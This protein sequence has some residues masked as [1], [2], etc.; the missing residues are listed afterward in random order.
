[1]VE[2]VSIGK[3][4]VDGLVPYVPSFNEGSD[5]RNFLTHR[6][7]VD[8]VTKS[9][10]DQDVVVKTAPL[11]LPL[12]MNLMSGPHFNWLVNLKKIT[13]TP[14][15]HSS[16]HIDRIY[17]ELMGELFCVT[18]SDQ[19]YASAVRSMETQQLVNFSYNTKAS[20][21]V[22]EGTLTYAGEMPYWAPLLRNERHSMFAVTFQ[23]DG[24]VD[25]HTG[26]ATFGVTDIK[27]TPSGPPDKL[28]KF[29]AAME[30]TA[31]VVG[32]TLNA[33]YA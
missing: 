13:N 30:R 25:R 26:K 22:R 12:K 14:E 4:F 32:F 20:I 10:V 28:S 31:K 9:E 3:Y 23:I 27:I 18:V 21:Q 15:L 16:M 6:C 19:P 24:T 33:I 2:F 17:F 8:L 29:M 7:G 11:V 1:M 5:A